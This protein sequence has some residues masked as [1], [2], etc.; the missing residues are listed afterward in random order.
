MRL[1]FP[2]AALV[3]SISNAETKGNRTE[4][5]LGGMT[6]TKLKRKPKL[7]EMDW[8]IDFMVGKMRKIMWQL[9]KGFKVKK[10]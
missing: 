10:F 3:R 1:V 7:T 2:N 5:N 4:R 8:K 6:V 9:E